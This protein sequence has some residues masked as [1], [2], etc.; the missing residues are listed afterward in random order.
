MDILRI[1]PVFKEV[2]WGGSRLHTDFGYDIPSDHTGECWAVSAHPDGECVIDGGEYDGVLLS[3][4]WDEHRELFGGYDS[5]RFPLLTK[6]IDAND[7]LSIQVHPDDSYAAVHENGSLGKM[8]CWYIID[9]DEDASIII[10]HN[11]KTKEEL[12]E[13]IDNDR[14][15]ELIRRVS[16]KKGDFFQIDPG[17]V[18][19]IKAGTLILETQQS[20]DITYRLYDYGRLQNGKPRELHIEKSLDVIEVPFVEKRALGDGDSDSWL[21]LLYSCKYYSVWKGALTSAVNTSGTEEASDGMGV[22]DDAKSASSF[23]L[24]QEMEQYPFIICSVIS[25]EAELN[26]EE[27]KKGDHFIIPAGMG[28]AVFKGEAE[29]ILSSPVFIEE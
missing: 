26:G 25:G 5:D 24:P 12:K 15:D 28:K 6:I 23:E 17:T 4:L 22:S 8:E 19:A 3:K 2:L 16:V 27:L 20:S 18:H 9:C 1:K 10:G 21:K 13:M 7:D 14:W 11:A 29:L